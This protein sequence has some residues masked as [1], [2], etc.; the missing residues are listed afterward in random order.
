MQAGA[1]LAGRGEHL[2]RR[3]HP[4]GLSVNYKLLLPSPKGRGIALCGLF[5]C[6]TA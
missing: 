3:P 6:T 2:H 1:V 4:L 5:S